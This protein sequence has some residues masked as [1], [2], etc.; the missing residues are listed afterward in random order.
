MGLQERHGTLGMGNV[1]DIHRIEAGLLA[2]TLDCIAMAMF[3]V[4]GMARILHVNAT[5]R[6]LLADASVLCCLNGKLSPFDRRAERLF[7]EVIAAARDA[8]VDAKG[9]SL[10][11]L[12]TCDGAQWL[13]RVLPLT[14]RVG[15][16]TNTAHAA[17]AAVLIHRVGLD[18]ADGLTTVANVYS[19][20][21]AEMRVGAAIIETGGVPEAAPALGISET[22][23]KTHL[24]HIFQKTG[25][26]RQADLVKLVAG[27]A[28][29]LP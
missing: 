13:V 8:P 22:T 9:V 1:V 29:P 17:V 3:V 12:I 16:Q 25:T 23:V 7:R 18:V 11:P 10:P 6:T 26:R 15:R 19:L 5:G 27:F 24:Q 14:R 21:P 28:S 4:D 2:D 20:T